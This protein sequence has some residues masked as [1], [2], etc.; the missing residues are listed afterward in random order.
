MTKSDDVTEKV[1]AAFTSQDQRSYIEIEIC[2]KKSA[3]EIFNTLQEAFDIY[4][5]SYAQVTRWV[6]EFKE[7]RESVRG[8]HC[9]GRNVTVTWYVHTIIKNRLGMRKV[10]ARW[11]PHR[12]TSVQ[13]ECHMSMAISHLSLLLMKLGAR[14]KE[15]IKTEDTD[16]IRI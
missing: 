16:D 11:I 4:A 7:G 14:V 13:T 12:L 1:M 6:K 3:V 5:L 8:N 2:R 9:A 15:T 10:S